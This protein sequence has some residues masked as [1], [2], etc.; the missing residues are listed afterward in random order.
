[1]GTEFYVRKPRRDMF[2][3]IR[4]AVIG[5]SMGF[6][7]AGG[8]S[9][10]V[11]QPSRAVSDTMRPAL[12]KG[13]MVFT[14]KLAYGIRLPFI[15]SRETGLTIPFGKP[16][17]GDVVLVNDPQKPVPHALVRLLAFPVYAFTFGR[18]DLA[19]KH[20]VIKRVVALPTDKVSIRFKRVYVNDVLL[21]ETWPTL[22]TDARILPA[23]VSQRDEI[24]AFVVPY[25]HYYLL[26][27]NRD[28]SYDSRDF[29]PQPLSAIEGKVLVK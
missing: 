23:S 6:L 28:Y 21:K 25:G 1:M 15:Q 13:D 8:L 3:L 9:E 2:A 10:F 16:K 22:T 29:G 11:I 19:P 24:A 18:V 26:G 12:K 5:V 4:R 17:T 7:A 27:D 20:A 14:L